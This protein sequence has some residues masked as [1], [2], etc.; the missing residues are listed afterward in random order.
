MISLV[1]ARAVLLAHV[2]FVLFLVVGGPLSIRWRR[3]LPFHL[4]VVAITVVINRTGLDCPLTGLEKDLLRDAG[5]RPYRGGF[6]EHHFVEPVHPSG[7]GPGVT[8]VLIAIW[9]VPT[10]ASYAYLWLTRSSRFDATV[11]V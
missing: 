7:T 2:T 6:I 5:R 4:A 8:I 3:L 9:L 10:V 11:A 1:L